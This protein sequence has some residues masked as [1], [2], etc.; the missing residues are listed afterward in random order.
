MKIGSLIWGIKKH[1]K[2]PHYS[3]VVEA[4]IQMHND[5]FN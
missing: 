1:K 4:L 2:A 3:K 5:F